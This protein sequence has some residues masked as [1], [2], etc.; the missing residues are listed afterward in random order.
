MKIFPYTLPI[1]IHLILYDIAHR[2]VI[3]LFI[4]CFMRHQHK[5]ENFILM[6]NEPLLMLPFT[7]SSTPSHPTTFFHFCDFSSHLLLLLL[8]YN[9]FFFSFSLFSEKV[10]DD[11]N[12]H[13]RKLLLLAL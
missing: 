7:H 11:I 9:N 4:T 8:F 12:F 10:P 2:M 3:Y 5:V 6:I 1:P 13:Y